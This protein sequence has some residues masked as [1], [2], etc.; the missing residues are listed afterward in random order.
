MGCLEIET[1]IDCEVAKKVSQSASDL[2]TQNTLARATPAF[3]G[4]HPVKSF[5]AAGICRIIWK[6]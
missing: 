5:G 4:A 3:F 6:F 2:D 1:N